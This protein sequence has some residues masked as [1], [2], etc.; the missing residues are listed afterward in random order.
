MEDFW[1]LCLQNGFSVAVAAYLLVRMEKR[2]DELTEAIR[3]LESAITHIGG[4]MNSE[5]AS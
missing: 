5:T 3:R 4:G 1:S 2:L